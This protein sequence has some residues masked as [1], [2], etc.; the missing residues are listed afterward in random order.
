[1]EHT[2]LGPQASKEQLTL[3]AV[4]IPPL[5]PPFHYSWPCY[6][7]LPTCSRSENLACH[8]LAH[9]WLQP[10]H[11]LRDEEQSDDTFAEQPPDM[12][13]VSAHSSNGFGW[14]RHAAG[15]VGLAVHTISML[16]AQGTDRHAHNMLSNTQH[17]PRVV[18]RRSSRTP[19]QGHLK[20]DSPLQGFDG[21][22]EGSH[23]DPLLLLALI[24]FAHKQ[25]GPYCCAVQSQCCLT[26]LCIHSRQ[27][28]VPALHQQLCA[29]LLPLCIHFMLN[30]RS[31]R[32]CF[33]LILCLVAK[34]L[35]LTVNNAYQ[36]SQVAD[37][38]QAILNSC[39]HDRTGIAICM[40]CLQEHQQH[41]YASV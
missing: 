3:S 4:H 36:I 11:M 5:V 17:L 10:M 33:L 6:P 15:C 22:W 13:Q 24:P 9:T 25:R 39:L 20:R 40:Q 28:L 34:E 18:L 37:Q 35:L 16:P 12:S 32:A 2:D 26:H 14:W 8:S 23:K 27:I 30:S 19:E 31:E 21:T 1:M 38:T 29:E 41:V 7:T